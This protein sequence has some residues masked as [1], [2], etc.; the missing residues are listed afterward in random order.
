MLRNRRRNS[1]WFE[2]DDAQTREE[3]SDEFGSDTE[4][5]VLSE[6]LAGKRSNWNV[7]EEARFQ[8]AVAEYGTNFDVVAEIVGTRNSQQCRGHYAARSGHRY[9]AW[10]K[11]KPPQLGTAASAAARDTKNV[12]HPELKHVGTWDHKS[13]AKM[14]GSDEAVCVRLRGHFEKLFRT[15]ARGRMCWDKVW[16]RTQVHTRRCHITKY[17]PD[18]KVMQL[19]PEEFVVST[20]GDDF[21]SLIITVEEVLADGYFSLQFMTRYHAAY[22]LRPSVSKQEGADQTLLNRLT[23]GFWASQFDRYCLMELQQ[24]SVP[25]RAHDL[26][27]NFAHLIYYVITHDLDRD[28]ATIRALQGLT[29]DDA[30]VTPKKALLPLRNLHVKS[31]EELLACL[32]ELTGQVA[33]KR[34]QKKKLN[35]QVVKMR[36][37]F[38]SLDSFI[39]RKTHVHPSSTQRFLGI[40]DGTEL[41]GPNDGY[42]WRAKFSL[43]YTMEKVIDDGKRDVN[44]ALHAERLY[45]GYTPALVKCRAA[46]LDRCLAQIAMTKPKPAPMVSGTLSNIAQWPMTFATVCDLTHES[47]IEQL[48]C[49][50]MLGAFQFVGENIDPSML[51][52]TVTFEKVDGNTIVNTDS[53]T[54][55]MLTANDMLEYITSGIVSGGMALD[56]WRDALNDAVCAAKEAGTDDASVTW[57]S[58]LGGLPPYKF[59]LAKRAGL[60]SEKPMNAIRQVA[61]AY[62]QYLHDVSVD[63]QALV[64]SASNGQAASVS[65]EALRTC[66]QQAR[67]ALINLRTCLRMSPQEARRRLLKNAFLA[68][69]QAKQG[70]GHA[71][72]HLMEVP[73]MS[74]ISAEYELGLDL[75]NVVTWNYQRRLGNLPQPP[76]TPLAIPDSLTQINIGTSPTSKIPS[77]ASASSSEGRKRKRAV[78]LQAPTAKLGHNKIGP[79]LTL[80]ARRGPKIPS[81]LLSKGLAVAKG[82]PNEILTALKVSHSNHLTKSKFAGVDKA[83]FNWTPEEHDRFMEALKLYENTKKKWFMIAQYVETRTAHQCRGHYSAYTGNRYRRLEEKKRRQRDE[84]N[85]QEDKMINNTERS[86][87]VKE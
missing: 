15:P 40:R 76:K 13:T 33:A 70:G 18:Y 81:D 7:D 82:E 28:T 17:D 57:T 23:H 55:L 72:L 63:L 62:M 65:D 16:L 79:K 22:T 80:K 45:M 14:T 31:D 86:R 3:A 6:K 68:P 48:A 11:Q 71:T 21:G 26:E 66:I 77:P 61:G 64:S 25:T 84:A 47:Y 1:A 4:E 54:T 9:R 29:Y 2:M 8:Q 19:T 44:V 10:K 75:S 87:G 56:Q 49:P 52:V 74:D 27:T 41:F 34:T 78:V 50:D 12:G 83:R 59:F 32:K 24:P 69:A 39:P 53:R 51:S 67:E 85:K 36:G 37:W 30:G 58:K 60:P 20:Q 42:K 38:S 73:V 5:V 35:D 43:A 46:L